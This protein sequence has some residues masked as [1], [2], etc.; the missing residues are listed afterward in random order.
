MT[1]VPT[2]SPI[3]PFRD[4]DY[5]QTMGG[6]GADAPNMGG[7]GNTG[8]LFTPKPMG[9]DWTQKAGLALQGLNTLGSL[10]TG[11]KSLG[12]ANKQFAFQKEFANANL[13]NQIKSYNTALADRSRS[14]AAMEGQT[15]EQAQ[16]Y[17]DANK[18]AR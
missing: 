10:W 14:R 16:A 7:L 18:M 4:W 17:I 2:N 5:S 12:L 15:P 8:G 11:F 3:I 6:W 9:M 13:A 1:T